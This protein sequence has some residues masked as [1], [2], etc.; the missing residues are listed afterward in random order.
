MVLCISID[1]YQMNIPM[2][3]PPDQDTEF[4][5][6]SRSL[7]PLH[8]FIINIPS[9]SNHSSDQYQ[10]WLVLPGLNFIWLESHTILWQASYASHYVY[11]MWCC[12]LLVHCSH[13]Y[14]SEFYK[15][16]NLLIY[17]TVDEY[18]SVLSIMNTASQTR[19][20]TRVKWEGR[21]I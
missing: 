2:E 4:Y 16:N 5:Q 12:T 11:N 17:S 6:D 19:A 10:N 3:L 20:E 8:T 1:V 13:C 18:L 21:K 15:Y 14:I 7:P 9:K